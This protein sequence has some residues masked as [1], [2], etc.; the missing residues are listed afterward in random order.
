MSVM[1]KFSKLRIENSTVTNDYPGLLSF[2]NLNRVWTS[3]NRDWVSIID[4]TLINNNRD[5]V[6]FIHPNDRSRYTSLLSEAFENKTSFTVDVRYRRSD[7]KYIF[8]R[9]LAKP[10]R[11]IKGEFTGFSFVGIEISDLY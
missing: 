11:N 2:I 5:K 1:E 6:D 10:C 3:L 8:I 7:G 4:S 9:E